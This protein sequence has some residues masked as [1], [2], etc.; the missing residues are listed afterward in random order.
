M[1]AYSWPR[2]LIA[3][4]S[5]ADWVDRGRLRPTHREWGAYLHAVAVK[6]GAEIVAD[7]VTAL[8]TEAG[9]WRLGL[10]GGGTLEADGVVVTGPGP[11]VTVPGQP[12]R[13]PARPGRP[14]LLAAPG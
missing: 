1:M 13:S 8:E 7:E 6:C 14:R 5:Y 4:G 12:R 9:R 10:A 11:P 2:N 3:G